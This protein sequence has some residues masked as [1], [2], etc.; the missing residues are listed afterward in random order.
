MEREVLLSGIGGQGVQ[1]AA[2]VLAVAAVDEGRD[3]Q[4]FG[5]YGGMM[6]GGNTD[7]T[8]VLADSRVQ[9]R[10]RWTRPG[11]RRPCTTSS[12]GRPGG[13]RVRR[14]A[15]SSSNS[16]VWEGRRPGGPHGGGRARHRPGRRRRQRHRGGHGDAGRAVHRD[17]RRVARSLRDAA[18]ASVPAYRS[19]HLELNERALEIGAGAL[20]GLVTEA[21]PRPPWGAGPR[22]A[23]AWL[24]ARTVLTRGTVVIDVD[25]CKGCELCIDACPPGVLV[26]TTHDVN[27]RGYRYPLLVAGC[28]GCR[29][30][31]QICPDFVFQVYKYDDPRWS[32]PRDEHWVHAPD[33]APPRPVRE[34]RLL[35]AARPS[36]RP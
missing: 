22:T 30:C 7:A 27:A 17:R 3:V 28:T 23:A 26:M 21:W 15:S 5:S 10:R 19:Q 18:R 32:S 25:A 20:P 34:R 8:L 4:L 29:A 12:P 16:S 31:S 2:Q 36:P 35:R 1:L 13:G 14:R 11:R 6:R 24:R 33:R 9:R